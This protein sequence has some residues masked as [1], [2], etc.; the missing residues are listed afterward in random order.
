MLI[1]CST[2]PPVL[3]HEGLTSKPMTVE[4]HGSQADRKSGHANVMVDTDQDLKLVKNRSSCH[5]MTT[6]TPTRGSLH[7]KDQ[8]CKLKSVLMAIHDDRVVTQQPKA[9]FLRFKLTV[10]CALI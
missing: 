5:S 8:W 4:L 9:D 10:S 2:Q 7:G 3:A 6:Q 1:S